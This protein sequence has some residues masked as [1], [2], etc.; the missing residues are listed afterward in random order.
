MSDT[1]VKILDYTTLIQLNETLD[2]TADS[3][4]RV[5]DGVNQYFDFILDQMQRQVD[6]I[7]GLVEEA[8]QRLEEAEADLSSCESSQEWDEDDHCYRP[9]C[10]YEKA[11]VNSARREY[12]EWQSKYEKAKGI[13]SDVKSEIDK[14]HQCP[15]IITPGGGDFTIEYTSG[16]HTNS[17]TKKMDE[18]IEVVEEYIGAKSNLS[19]DSKTVAQVHSEALEAL[20]GEK[21]DNNNEKAAKFRA[22]SEDVRERMARTQPSHA[23]ANEIVICSGCHRP[24]PLCIC[25]RVRE[26]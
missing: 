13:L 11:E 22:S 26:R 4:M 8:K 24:L 6:E 14:Y 3:L 16:E 21:K 9:S 2:Y 20:E 15:G 17:S 1:Q 7:E 12:D 19:G 10:D 23:T 18:I 5:R 25:Q